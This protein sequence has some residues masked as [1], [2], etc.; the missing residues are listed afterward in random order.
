[1]DFEEYQ[2]ATASTDIRPDPDDPALPLLGLAGEVGSLVTEYKKKLRAGTSYTSFE[3][4]V[5]EDLGDLLWYAATLA[6]TL[7]LS[8]DDIAAA[9]LAKA[10]T[11][12]GDE[13]GPARQYD[14]GFPSEQQR[15]GR[16]ATP[17]PGRSLGGDA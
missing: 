11:A 5:T 10:A 13:V 15:G 6:R 14:A 4:E 3:Q 9:N 2:R 8:L 7:G 1:M 12:W 16:A 17:T